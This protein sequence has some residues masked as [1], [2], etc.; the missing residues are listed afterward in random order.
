MTNLVKS[1]NGQVLGVHSWTAGF[2]PICCPSRRLSDN[3]A[4]AHALWIENHISTEEA[5][6]FLSAWFKGFNASLGRA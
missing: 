2:M 4:L 6:D 1:E 3:E 5:E